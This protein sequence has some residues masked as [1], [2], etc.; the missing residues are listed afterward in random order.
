MLEIIAIIALGKSISRIAKEKGRKPTMF[1]LIM[2]LMWIGF[3][4]T[5]AM[6]GAIFFGEGLMVYVLALMGAALG[7]LG[8]YLIAKSAAPNAAA[9]EAEEALDSDLR[10]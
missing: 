7:G 1:V 2:V 6:I 4:I 3:E 9:F 5:G 10:R 8:A